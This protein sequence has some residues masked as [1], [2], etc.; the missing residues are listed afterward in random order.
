[1]F[2]VFDYE[3]VNPPDYWGSDNAGRTLRVICTLRVLCPL[4]R[5]AKSHRL[6]EEQGNGLFEKGVYMDVHDCT[7]K[8]R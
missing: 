4:V 1:M 7:Q 5:F 8:L 6:D 2:T 3:P